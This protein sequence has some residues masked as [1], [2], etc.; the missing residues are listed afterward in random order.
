MAPD[1]VRLEKLPRCNRTS[2]SDDSEYTLSRNGSMDPN[3]HLSVLCD[4]E[5]ELILESHEIPSRKKLSFH[6]QGDV[7]IKDR[8]CIEFDSDE[9]HAPS[10]DCSVATLKDFHID[11]LAQGDNGPERLTSTC[12]DED[13]QGDNGPERLTS[14]SIDEDSQGIPCSS[15]SVKFGSR[16]RRVI[17]TTGYNSEDDCEKEDGNPAEEL[18]NMEELDDSFDKLPDKAVAKYAFVGVVRKQNER[19]NLIGYECKE[20]YEYYSAMGLSDEEVRQRVQTCSKHRAHYVPPE[21]P[22]HFW[23]VG[24]PDTQECEERGMQIPC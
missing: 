20:C 13:S 22:P 5:S 14:T 7:G 11:D 3:V 10:L 8:C 17:V 16:K 23:S 21:T 9:V 15:R 18:E 19:R 24:F 2:S 4:E 1:S 12:I 6:K